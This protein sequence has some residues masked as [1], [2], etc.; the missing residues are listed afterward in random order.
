[1]KREKKQLRLKKFKVAKLG[2]HFLRGGSEPANNSAPS[3]ESQACTNQ[4]VTSVFYTTCT[5]VPPR[6]NID[7]ECGK[8][9]S[10]ID[11]CRNI[12]G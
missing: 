4:A 1:M 7:N 6:T 10:A 2:M 11:T 12:G 9:N 8:N 3:E 5:I